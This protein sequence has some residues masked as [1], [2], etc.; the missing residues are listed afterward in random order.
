MFYNGSNIGL[1]NEPLFYAARWLLIN[2][3]ADAKDT[4]ETYRGSTMCLRAKVGDAAKLSVK[5]TDAGFFGFV[6]WKP[7][8]FAKGLY[9]SGQPLGVAA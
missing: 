7:S 4:I 2:G 1:S 5:E 9:P 8:P 6:P 3:K